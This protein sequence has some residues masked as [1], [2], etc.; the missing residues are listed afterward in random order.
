[1]S[2]CREPNDNERRRGVVKSCPKGVCLT[3]FLSIF[4]LISLI[5][6]ISVIAASFANVDE[7]QVRLAPR[8][9]RRVRAPC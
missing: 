8:V 6:I 2:C 4:G 3:V 5:V 1:M 9:A 7:G